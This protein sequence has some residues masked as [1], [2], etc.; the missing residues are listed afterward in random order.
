MPHGWD[1][2]IQKLLRLPLSALP[3]SARISL[4]HALRG[5]RE[6][7]R[8]RACDLVVL[9]RAKSGR[10][11]LRA[12]LSRLYQRRH[13]LPETQLLEFDNFHR[14]DPAVPKI[15]FTHGRY[16]ADFFEASD[17]RS[18]IGEKKVIFLARHPCDVAVSEY[19][20]ST[21]RAR[22]HK[23]E[24]YGVDP[25]SSMF[26]FVMT[27]GLGLP[28]IIDYLNGWERRI[29]GHK[30]VRVV[31]YEDLC[32]RP[33]ETLRGIV[34]FFRAPF[35]EEEI[36]DAVDFASFDNL[37]ELERRDF[38]GNSRLAPR[39]PSDP[40]SFKVRR[41]KVGG[42]RDYFDDAQLARMDAL[43]RDGLSPT[44][45]YGAVVRRAAGF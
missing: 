37:R 14:Q 24:L 21:R 4:T 22:K 36:R 18:G 35:S 40:D 25:K 44:F 42:Y 1:E 30:Q 9:S 19:F 27:S 16:L 29:S 32:A 3:R 12:M 28:P 34:T 43:V 20:Q 11:W 17:P 45:G 2:Q 33:V 8:A 6:R 23:L 39:D 10:T 5:R 15:L 7:R 13:G 26:D 38:F 41:G 31:R